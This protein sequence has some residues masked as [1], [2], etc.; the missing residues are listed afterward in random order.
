[1]RGDGLLIVSIIN[2]IACW[3]LFVGNLYERGYLSALCQWTLS[4]AA[5]ERFCP[6]AQND[7]FAPGVPTPVAWPPGPT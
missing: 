6:T 1:M 2:A 5:E 3:A 7:T 4:D